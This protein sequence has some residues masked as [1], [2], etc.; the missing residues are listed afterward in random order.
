MLMFTRET[1]MKR[2]LEL[3][4]I[5]AARESGGSEATVL[6]L[7]WLAEVEHDL[8]KLR[9]PLVGLLS[10]ERSRLLAFQDGALDPEVS[11]KTSKLKR[12][13]ATSAVT[14]ARVERELR[15]AMDKADLELNEYRGKLVQLLAVY[16]SSY[17]LPHRAA[18]SQVWKKLGEPE[19]TRAMYAFVSGGLKPGDLIPLLDEVLENL[20]ENAE[21]LHG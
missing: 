10:G 6:T 19:E 8:K 4:P 3:E 11:D 21:S 15:E 13:R 16:S 18:P 5:L 1:L 7:K 12:G 9:H 14:L 20:W 17:G 2:L